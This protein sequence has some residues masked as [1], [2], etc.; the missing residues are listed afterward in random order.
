M[1]DGLVTRSATPSARQAP[2]TKVVFPAPTSPETSTMSPG[3]SSAAMVA[4]TRSV[5]AAE[6]VS[7]VTACTAWIIREAGEALSGLEQPELVGGG[8]G[9]DRFR[10]G[11][12]LLG[13]TAERRQ[14][15]GE[16]AGHRLEVG[17]EL[18]EHGACPEGGGRVEDRI[19]EHRAAGQLVLPAGRP[20]R[21]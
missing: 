15:L 10:L 3:P 6:S 16:Q 5:A 1:N 17:A 19:E 21:A 2:R 9:A 18:V 4:A 8:R 7:S 12:G 14:R 20:A 13:P 11:L